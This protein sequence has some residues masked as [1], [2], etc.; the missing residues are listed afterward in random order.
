MMGE[1]RIHSSEMSTPRRAAGCVDNDERALPNF[2]LDSAAPRCKL[3]LYCVA[4]FRNVVRIELVSRR[5]SAITASDDKDMQ[6]KYPIR[7][8]ANLGASL[9]LLPS[10]VRLDGGGP[11]LYLVQQ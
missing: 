6:F 7:S 5:L 3:I 1:C 9:L 11:V 2:A 10:P 8:Q 4:P